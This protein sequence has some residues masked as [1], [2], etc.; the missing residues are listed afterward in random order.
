MSF[1]VNKKPLI[2]RCSALDRIVKCSGY[3][4]LANASKDTGA[5]LDGTL[6]HKYLEDACVH[7]Q[8]FA[9]ENWEKNVSEITAKKDA[10]TEPAETLRLTRDF[11]DWYKIKN[12]P[13]EIP[14]AYLVEFKLGHTFE[15]MNVT[16]RGTADLVKV[17][18]THVDVLDWKNYSDPSW[19]PPAK[20]NL[21]LQ[22][23]AWLAAKKLKCT[24]AAV[25]I[26]LIKQ[27]EIRSAF[28]SAVDLQVIESRIR[29]IAHRASQLR[30]SYEFGPWCSN[31]LANDKCV[32][33]RKNSYFI[34]PG[35]HKWN[36]FPPQD[37]E[38]AVT[39]AL[40]IKAAEA[41]VKK[42][43]DFVKQYVDFHGPIEHN[44]MEYRKC[45]MK[46]TWIAKTE[47]AF[48]DIEEA[49]G[50]GVF[51]V[52]NISSQKLSKLVKSLGLSD[53]ESKALFDKIDKATRTYRN[54]FYAWRKK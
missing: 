12:E 35:L 38:D 17:T 5:T 21:Q 4:A 49:V 15:A 41:S 30:D 3:A 42:A 26:G 24:T 40:R 8:Q 51:E 37:S 13:I 23:Y 44:D 19:L 20:E 32:E 22:A 9:E 45:S 43:K 14:G 10:R 36:E 53:S 52:I 25:H 16:V 2:L 54:E 6:A 39:L 28:F 33:Y 50:A 27:K 7:G 31:C 29:N 18:G 1:P 34:T 48:K 11:L 47:Q 46:K